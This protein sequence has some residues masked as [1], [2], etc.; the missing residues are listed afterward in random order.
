MKWE[1]DKA[2]H[3]SKAEENQRLN[4]TERSGMF[5]LSSQGNKLCKLSL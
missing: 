1:N 4:Q 2:N 3:E 5:T